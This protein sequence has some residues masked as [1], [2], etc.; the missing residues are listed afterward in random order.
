MRKD[1]L[2]ARLGGDE[3]IIL[4]KSHYEQANLMELGHKILAMTKKQFEIDIQDY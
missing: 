3:F 4:I 2:V 1:D